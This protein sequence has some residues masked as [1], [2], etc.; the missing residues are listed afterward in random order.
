MRTLKTA[1]KYLL[2]GFYVFAGVNHFVNPD[3]Y[4]RIMPGYLP[5]HLP[6]V[7]LSGVFEVLL[8]VLVVIPRFTR[9]AAW[10]LILLLIA[11]FPANLHMAV[12]PHLYPEVSPVAL[13]IRLPIQ[14]LLIAWAFWYTREPAI[15]TPSRHAVHPV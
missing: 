5:W 13:W 3:F 6:L 10:G 12:N 4:V 1:L 2:G 11:I 15:R 8:G 7:Y 9:V 14:G